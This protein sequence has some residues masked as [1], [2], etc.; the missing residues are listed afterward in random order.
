MRAADWAVGMAL[1][2]LTGCAAE[3]PRYKPAALEPLKGQGIIYV[4]R[5][6][7][8]VGKR[9]EN[10][11]VTVNGVSYGG[12]RP[13]SFIAANVPAGEIKVTVQQAMFL[14]LP[15]IPKS[16]EVTVVP[17]SNSY[18]RVNQSIVSAGGAAGGGVQVMQSIS[19]EEVPFDVGQQE[20]E[21]TR[22]NH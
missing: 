11:H 16:V 10:P 1:L 3:G 21:A 7:E 5:P 19:I 8:E 9:G 12:M 4:Y 14:V 2:A 18:V 13:G 22:Q 6:L 15:T 20:L 17:G